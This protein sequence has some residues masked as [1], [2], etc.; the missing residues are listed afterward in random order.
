MQAEWSGKLPGDY[1]VSWR[2]NT[3]SQYESYYLQSA[4]IRKSQYVYRK[5]PN[6]KG[7]IA[8]MAAFNTTADLSGGFYEDG[9]LGPVKITKNIAL[10]IALLSWTLLDAEK[11][12]REDENVMVLPE[13]ALV[14]RVSVVS[15]SGA[16]S[17]IAN[18]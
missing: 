14:T 12:M 17:A 10:N 16:L 2:S 7:T 11:T 15:S 8:N 4:G 13:A 6:D 18:G 3:G 5:P 9:Q 1:P